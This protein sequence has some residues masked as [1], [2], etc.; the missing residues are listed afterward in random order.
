MDK[1]KPNFYAIIP[2]NVRYASDLSELQKLLY[3]EI[4]AL[5]DKH[6]YC[7]ASNSYFARLYNK[8]TK[9]ISATI[10]DMGKKW[11]LRLEQK[12]EEW[13]YRKIYIWELK[14]LRKEITIPIQEKEE[15]IPVKQD[16][17]IPVKQDTLSHKSGNIVI[18]DNTTSE[19]E[20]E[21]PPPT[22]H[23]NIDFINWMRDVEIRG[24]SWLKNWN[25]KTGRQDIMND[26]IK[27]AMY[28]MMKN[29]TFDIFEQR[30]S[31]YVDVLWVISEKKLK[32]YVFFQI[33]EYDF[34]Q[35]LSKINQFYGDVPTILSKIARNEYKTKIVWMIKKPD[36][37]PHTEEPQKKILNEEER[38]KMNAD[39]KEKMQK[40]IAK[41]TV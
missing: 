5:A 4:T 8:T 2:A 34:L 7:F 23:K 15:G 13:W 9:W 36:P 22:S 30:I 32:G 11:Y 35:F 24:N 1:E 12:K 20:V 16:T 18:Q 10:G 28:A 6:G 17:H 25:E 38:K 39:F 31:K 37:V 29:V 40:F 19:N 3:G 41:K 14:R 27:K 26:E 33:W 21:T